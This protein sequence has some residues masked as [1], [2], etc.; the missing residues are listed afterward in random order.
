MTFEWD[1]VPDDE[2]PRRANLSNKEFRVGKRHSDK[3]GIIPEAPL[4]L[5]V[6][7]SFELE[8]RDL[9]EAYRRD[10]RVRIN[11]VEREWTFGDMNRVEAVLPD[12]VG[13][14]G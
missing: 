1:I 8:A 10:F 11:P 2:E 12:E 9:D 13:A 14:V 5:D 3:I 7:L 4:P 6:V